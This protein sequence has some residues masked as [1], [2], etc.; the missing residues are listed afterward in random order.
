MSTVITLCHFCDIHG[1]SV[2]LSCHAV[3]QIAP[4]AQTQCEQPVT[5]KVKHTTFY[6]YHYTN[7]KD[8][9]L[10]NFFQSSKISQ[11]ISVLGN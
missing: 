6:Y 3:Q 2:L 11:L 5:C 8:I 9:W 10:E 1:P 7:L 4:L